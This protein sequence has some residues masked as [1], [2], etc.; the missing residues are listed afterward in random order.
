MGWKRNFVSNQRKTDQLESSMAYKKEKNKKKKKKKKKMMKKRLFKT[1]RPTAETEMVA[2]FYQ[3]EHENE[4]ELTS[5][6]R[7]KS[8]LQ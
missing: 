3:E 2:A 5:R 7:R 4:N 6:G 8:V 1:T